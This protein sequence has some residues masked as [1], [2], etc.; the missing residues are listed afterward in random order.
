M[1]TTALATGISKSDYV[2]NYFKQK[3][4]NQV[5][6]NIGI[7][8]EFPILSLDCKAWNRK[9]IPSLCEFIRS[10]LNFEDHEA[11]NGSPLSFVHPTTEDKISFEVSHSTLEISLGPQHTLIELDAA[12]QTYF[13]QL[14][15]FLYNRNC[16][17]GCCGLHPFKY[18]PNYPVLES[19]HYL[20]ITGYLRKYSDPSS[21]DYR[22]AP[23]LMIGSQTHIEVPYDDIYFHLNHYHALGWVES[24]LFAN[25]PAKSTLLYRDTLLRRS[26]FGFNPK[27]VCYPD[28]YYGSNQ[29]V[30]EEYLNKSIFTN[31]NNGIPYFFKPVQLSRLSMP[32]EE[33]GNALNLSSLD[34][35]LAFN[36]VRLSQFGTLEIRST[37][38]QPLAHIMTPAAF[39]LAIREASTEL[40]EML[41]QFWCLRA[42]QLRQR[43]NHRRSY[44]NSMSN[45][46]LKIIE[47]LSTALARRCFG[48]EKYLEILYTRIVQRTNPALQQICESSTPRTLNAF[49]IKNSTP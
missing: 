23:W 47:I 9:M 8:F 30:F 15:E 20:N 16:Y 22:T 26:G 4:P 7:E 29:G 27:N 37:C 17:L 38:Q 45:Q 32:T 19:P 34:Q 13:R 44:F 49:L 10:G 35:C 5:D 25:S 12:F 48:E 43:A 24:L 33:V 36:P 21:L 28:E 2:A 42:E 40:N 46:L 6:N 31:Q 3:F 14:Q 11:I 18:Y 1:T 39:H 41:P